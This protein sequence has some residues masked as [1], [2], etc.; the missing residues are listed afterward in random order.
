MIKETIMAAKKT[1]KK[2]TTRKT[3][4][5]VAAPVSLYNKQD[6]AHTTMFLLFTVFAVLISGFIV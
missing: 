6:R 4:K 2:T 1:V 3:A 5:K